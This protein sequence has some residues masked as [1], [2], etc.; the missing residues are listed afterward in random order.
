VAIY[1]DSNKLGVLARAHGLV[2]V[3]RQGD[4]VDYY[5]GEE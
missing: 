3:H 5:E 4:A 2:S 1:P